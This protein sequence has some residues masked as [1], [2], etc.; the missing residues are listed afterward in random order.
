[1]VLPE[2]RQVR[3]AA[4]RLRFAG[5]GRRRLAQNLRMKAFFFIVKPDFCA[6]DTTACKRNFKSNLS[7]S[8]VCGSLHRRFQANTVLEF[9]THH[10]F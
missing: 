7:Q 4:W 1:M 3:R 5:I 9:A 6:T 2:I 8:R 10:F